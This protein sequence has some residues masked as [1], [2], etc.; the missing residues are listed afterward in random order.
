MILQQAHTDFETMYISLREKEGRVYPDELVSHLP[1]VPTTHQHSQEWKIRA[2]SCSRLL[3]YLGTIRKSPLR[4]LEVG[5]GNGWLSARLSSLP[6]ADVTG[7]DINR[8]ELEQAKR[9]FGGRPN[10][11]FIEGD[12]R[13]IHANEEF[14]VI[15]FAASIQYFSSLQGI[16][17]AALGV[18]SP[19]GQI[20]IL[21]SHF[22]HDGEVEAAR[23]RSADY[24]AKMGFSW[25]SGNYF[26]HAIS[27]LKPYQ[28]EI[29]EEPTSLRSKI[30]NRPLHWVKIEKHKLV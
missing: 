4:I 3:K 7:I 16:L 2:K 17:D 25:L 29:L 23:I 27:A 14:D 24:F 5:S 22:Y 26:Q 9:V 6:N 30:F 11:R 13:G 21:D 1:D 8:Q 18:L 20:H 12:L 28:P 19:K 10:L 15:V